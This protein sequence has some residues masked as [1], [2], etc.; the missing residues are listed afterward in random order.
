MTNKEIQQAASERANK[1]WAVLE[2]PNEH[3]NTRDDFIAGARWAAEKLEKEFSD[4][5]LALSA[6]IKALRDL[7]RALILLRTL[8]DLQNGPPLWK[9]KEEWEAAMEK[10]YAFLSELE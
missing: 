2:K 9:E 10:I 3:D 1:H 4:L 6:G 5:D 8:A 7:D